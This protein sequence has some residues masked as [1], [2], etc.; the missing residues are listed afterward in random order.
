MVENVLMRLKAE[1]D[2][3]QRVARSNLTKEQMQKLVIAR[4]LMSTI[5]TAV[6]INDPIKLKSWNVTRNLSSTASVSIRW[7]CIMS[8]RLPRSI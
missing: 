7:I 8:W 4:Q 3:S 2:V 1:T 6:F 5:V